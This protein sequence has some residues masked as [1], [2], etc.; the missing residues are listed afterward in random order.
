MIS[1]RFPSIFERHNSELD[2][3]SNDLINGLKIYLNG[4]SYIIG[5]LALSEGKSPSKNINSAPDDLDYNLFLYSG[6]LLANF[7]NNKPIHLTTGFPFSTHKINRDIAKTVIKG[8]HIIDYDASTFSSESKQSTSVEIAEVEI[9]PEMLGNIT[10]L[11]KGDAKI[12]GDFFVVSLGYG[13]FEAVLSTTNGI[14]QRTAV[15]T[16][17]LQYAIDIFMKELEK[18]H[19]LGLKTKNQIDAAFQND[20][21]FLNRKRLDIRNLKKNI[22]KSY[23]Q[24]I[25]SPMLLSA[26]TDTDFSKAKSLYITGGG[27][28]YRDLVN[29]FVEEFSD[30]IN[31]EVVKNPLTLAS[32]GY[33]INSLEN[34]RNGQIAVGLDIGNSNTVLTQGE[35]L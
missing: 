19:Y 31:T 6:L 28:L 8:K 25:I 1:Y 15:S 10:A 30:I 18:T 26:F 2:N 9:L 34:I 22:L 35:T 20:Y 4:E 24:D 7:D 32:K 5:N 33:Y 21:V 13:T 23:Y 16:S 11:R 14:V 27:A 3:V 12:D 29:C 17:G